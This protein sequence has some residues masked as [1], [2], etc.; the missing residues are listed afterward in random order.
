M[1]ADRSEVER[2]LGRLLTAH[3]VRNTSFIIT[4]AADPISTASWLARTARI[5]GSTCAQSRRKC[6]KIAVAVT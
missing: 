5:F 4:A 2:G 6:S 1:S 3:T